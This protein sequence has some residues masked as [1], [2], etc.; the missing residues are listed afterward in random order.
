MLCHVRLNG[1]SYFFQEESFLFFSF[2]FFGNV[3]N[4][5]SPTALLLSF[6]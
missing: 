2:L 3:F 6:A 4:P 1:R 5:E